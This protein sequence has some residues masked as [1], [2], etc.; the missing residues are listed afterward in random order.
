MAKRHR[1]DLERSRK[2]VGDS[3][4]FYLPSGPDEPRS[5]PVRARRDDSEPCGADPATPRAGSGG[6][7][8]EASPEVVGLRRVCPG[9]MTAR[10]QRDPGTSVFRS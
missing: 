2:V 7:V 1:P 10:T 6:T 9:P 4:R 3:E 8:G 5:Q